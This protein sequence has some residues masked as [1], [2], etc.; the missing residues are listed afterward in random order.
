VLLG[1]Q[2]EYPLFNIGKVRETYDMGGGQLLVIT[3]DRISMFD[4]V[5]PAVI[6]GK[7]IV[8]CQISNM[9]MQK[10][11]DIIPNHLIETN[12]DNFPKK[13][14]PWKEVLRDRAVIVKKLKMPPIEG[15]VRGFI[16]GSVWNDYQNNK[17]VGKY[18]LPTGMKLW[19]K[20]NPPVFTPSTK[21]MESGKH[22][23]NISC[24]VARNLFINSGFGF[25]AYD[26]YEKKALELF[27]ALCGYAAS[28]G[29]VMLD[30]KFE[31][32]FIDGNHVILGDELG[33]P[34]SSRYVDQEVY[35][36]AFN[37]GVNPISMG[38]QSMKN[39]VGSLAA[40]HGIGAGD[41]RFKIPK[42]P[43]K[44]ILETA[45]SYLDAFVRLGGEE[46]N[47]RATDWVRQAVY[48]YG[49]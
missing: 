34:D 16:G 4:R 21:E 11:S 26:L 37:N 46:F 29:I 45:A 3:T 44:I 47:P 15:I 25:A 42:L 35:R 6:P 14:S 23:Q 1:I 5:M 41:P 12:V 24:A 8:L 13:L 27:V 22:D 32:G 9:L 17:H 19:E 18:K 33:T 28:R 36:T 49:K 20:L 31:I 2:R 48:D 30:T 43:T 39:Y 7:G 38:R 10:F 40:A